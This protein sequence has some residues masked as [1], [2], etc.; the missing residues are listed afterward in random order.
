MQIGSVPLWRNVDPG[1]VFRMPVVQR[2]LGLVVL[3]V[4]S[5]VVVVT[6]AV[7]VIG[8]HVIFVPLIV[9]LAVVAL[10]WR[11]ALV[12]QPIEIRVFTDGRL[13]LR[14]A[15]RTRELRVED[16]TTVRFRG[17]RVTMRVSGRCISPI[18]T[19]SREL[20]LT[21]LAANPEIRTV[22]RPIVPMDPE[23]KRAN[24]RFGRW[25]LVPWTVA[26]VGGGGVTALQGNSNVG[27]WIFLG[28]WLVMMP[29]VIIDKRR[30]R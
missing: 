13:Q 1:R 18:I 15:L 23:R 3:C 8:D 7:Q 14:S 12:V 2:V 20:A 25:L 4:M 9:F 17:Q 19:D 30:N 10:F 24:R 27:K 6:V 26:I 29:M 11:Q 22:G 21:L 16:V 28:G 5:V